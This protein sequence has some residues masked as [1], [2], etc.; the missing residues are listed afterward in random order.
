MPGDI[1]ALVRNTDNINCVI[2]HDVKDEMASFGKQ[3]YPGFISSLG[4]PA[5]GLSASQFMRARIEPV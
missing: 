2:R 3:K 4:L 1:H 5:L